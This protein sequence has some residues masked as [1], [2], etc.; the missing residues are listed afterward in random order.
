MWLEACSV[1]FEGKKFGFYY[2]HNKNEWGS[3]KFSSRTYFEMSVSVAQII[4]E[5]GI[6]LHSFESFDI[7]RDDCFSSK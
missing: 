2:L 1:F 3:N 5:W 7:N 6:D 4:Q